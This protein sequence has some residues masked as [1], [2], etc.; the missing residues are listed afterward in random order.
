MFHAGNRI[1]RQGT[2]ADQ[3]WLITDGK[4]RVV[5][6]GRTVA[7]LGPGLRGPEAEEAVRAQGYT[8]GHF[9]QSFEYATIGGFVA[10]RSA[11]HPKRRSLTIWSRFTRLAPSSIFLSPDAA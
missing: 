6:G 11:G 5:R 4:V 7:T 10:T 9:P 2:P 3:F 1:F 8:I